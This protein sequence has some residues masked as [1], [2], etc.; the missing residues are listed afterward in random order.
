MGS[1]IGA[2]LRRNG[3]RVLTT[4]A[5]RSPRTAR[6]VAQAG[7]ETVPD[8]VTVVNQ[9]D[10]IL[11]VTP[12]G[13]ALDAARDIAAVAREIAAAREAA[14]QEA[15]DQQAT[16]QEATNHETM[17]HETTNHGTAV[18]EDPR[19]PLVADLNA[20]APSTVEHVRGILETVGLDLVDGSIS[21]GPPTQTHGPTIFLSGPRAAEIARLTWQ[22]ARPVIVGD[23]I[24]SASAVKM[25]TASV[26]KGLSGLLAQAMR[27]ADQHGVVEYVLADLSDVDG[28]AAARV[29]LAVTKADRY[30]GEMLEIAT[31]QADAGLTADLFR[32]YARVYEELAQTR[33][34]AGDP[35]TLDRGITPR[36]VL[37]QLTKRELTR[38]ELTRTE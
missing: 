14:T 16:A 15:P 35:E 6:L 11:V 26:Y 24:G 30:V 17:N 33:L 18:P 13:A 34:A 9:S 36:Q 8:L 3:H 38:T 27:T 20:I 28:H 19:S 12:P 4:V 1:G 25:C 10:V 32:A 22:P 21:G 37:D 23:Q 7:L 2:A 29:A 31:T 5:G